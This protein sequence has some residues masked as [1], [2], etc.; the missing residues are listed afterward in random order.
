MRF[1]K[2]WEARSDRDL[3]IRPSATMYLLRTH[4]VG[5][6]AL[7]RT[8]SAHSAQPSEAGTSNRRFYPLVET[9]ATACS[10]CGCGVGCYSAPA[11]WRPGDHSLL[12]RAAARGWAGGT[13]GM[14]VSW[15]PRPATTVL[16]AAVAA[17]CQAGRL[18]VYEAVTSDTS[19]PPREPDRLDID[20]EFFMCQEP[21]S[22]GTAPI[23]VL[24]S[25]EG[26]PLRLLL[27]YPATSVIVQLTLDE[28]GQISEETLTDPTHLITR[29][30]AY[31]QSE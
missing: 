1:T 31:P 28:Q 9:Q 29:R 13:K 11:T 22:D 10:S 24:T 20:A 27:G 16:A 8:Q 15:P 21:Y 6:F 30:L 4:I 25:S 2:L 14:L 19:R 5:E 12:L 23:A 7:R 3:S 17:T 18:A 26:Q